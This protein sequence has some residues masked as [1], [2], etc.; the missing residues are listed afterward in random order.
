MKS[1]ASV[2]FREGDGERNCAGCAFRKQPSS[3]EEVEGIVGN[4]AV[5]DE[6]AAKQNLSQIENQMFGQSV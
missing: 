4:A 3:C 1:K 5:C 2:N 6:W